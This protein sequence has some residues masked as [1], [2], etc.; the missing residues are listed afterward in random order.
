MSA[1]GD[2]ILITR[3]LA[4]GKDF[5]RELNALG[6]EAVLAPMLE[7]TP[8]KWTPFQN[9]PTAL[10][11]TSANAINCAGAQELAALCALPIYV[12]GK[13][14]EQAAR[15]AGFKT[16]HNAGGDG[17]DLIARLRQDAQGRQGARLGYLR[18]A[19]IT[20]D[21]ADIFG[22]NLEERIIYTAL[23]ATALPPENYTA[24]AF[25]SKR[26][27]EVFF[28]L[29][30]R[31]GRPP[32]LSSTKL[33]CISHSVLECVRIRA[34]DSG[35]RQFFTAKTPDRDGMTALIK[36]HCTSSNNAP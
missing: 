6:Y 26:T 24:V 1:Q 33:L 4:Q 9:N 11:A 17:A 30:A 35:E 32:P 2:V 16:I 5:A 25:F 7:I 27:A 34:E 29:Y 21:L 14:T 13:Q 19:D 31:A 10:I 36:A 15:N 18:G 8:Q 20:H 12:V 23:P 3:P 22:E 28:G